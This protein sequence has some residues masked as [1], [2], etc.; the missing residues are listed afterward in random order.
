MQFLQCDF[1]CIQIDTAQEDHAFLDVLYGD[2]I[3]KIQRV[4]FNNGARIV[5]FKSL[6][7]LPD[8]REE[9]IILVIRET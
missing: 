9:F 2:C 8:M 1:V 3:Q 7:K 4:F 6:G 5:Y